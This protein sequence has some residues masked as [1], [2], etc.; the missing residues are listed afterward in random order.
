MLLTIYDTEWP[1][2]WWCAVKKLLTHWLNFAWT[3]TSTATGTRLNFKVILS[4]RVSNLYSMLALLT[5]NV[6]NV[7]AEREVKLFCWHLKVGQEG[8]LH[9]RMFGWPVKV[10]VTWV[11]CVFV[12]WLP[13]DTWTSTL[14]TFKS[15]LNFKVIGQRSRSHGFFLFFFACMILQLPKDAW[16]CSLTTSRSLLNIKVKG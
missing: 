9:L 14:E 2:L 13:T 7:L 16:T 5:L 10:K 3:C 15:L 4:I 8:V 11:L 6:L 12:L 1:I